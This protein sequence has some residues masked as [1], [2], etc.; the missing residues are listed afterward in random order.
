MEAQ[1]KYQFSSVQLLSRVRLFVTHEPQHASLP[2]PSPTPAV[3]PNPSQWCHPTISS[4]VAPFS[5]CPQ[6]F[7]TSGS[8]Q[9]SQLF[10]LGGQSIAVSASTSVLPV[11]TQEM[12]CLDLLAQGTGLQE[13]FKNLLQ[14]RSSK[15]SILRCSAFFK[16]KY[17][18]VWFWGV[19]VMY[20]SHDRT[21]S[22]GLYLYF[23][24]EKFFLDLI[25]LFLNLTEHSN[26]SFSH[27]HHLVHLLH[28]LYH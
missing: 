8:F 26:L 25:I 12:D 14:H 2:Y 21:G 3:L 27:H 23:Y 6:S 19:L 11:N 16:E 1:E 5:S 7:P 9:M 17:R 28:L 15:A 4:S 22:W 13:D 18:L 24:F 10:P 20:S